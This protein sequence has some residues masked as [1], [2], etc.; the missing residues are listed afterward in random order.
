[1]A[2]LLKQD[3]TGHI[4]PWTEQLAARADMKPCEA[5]APIANPVDPVV[6]AV[7][8][9]AKDKAKS[10]PVVMEPPEVVESK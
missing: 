2:K 5:P 7:A 6:P 3:G 9:A 1:M 8:P 4:Y 10:A